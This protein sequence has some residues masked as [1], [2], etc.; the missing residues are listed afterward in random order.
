MH[1]SRFGR[2]ALGLCAL[3]LGLMAF[4]ASAAQAEVGSKW[5]VNGVD[6]NPHV[7]KVEVGVKELENKTGSLLSTLVGLATK[8][9]CTGE[10]MTGAVLLLEGH[11]SGGV[12]DYTGCETFLSGVLT[13][14]C[15]PTGGLIKTKKLLGL[16]LLVLGPEG[17]E[18]LV[19]IKPEEG[20]EF[21]VIESSEKCAVGQ[22][23]VIKGEVDLKDCKKEWGKE[24]ST[25]LLEESPAVSK[26]TA[27]NKPASLDGSKIV[28]LTGAHKGLTFSALGSSI[29]P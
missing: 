25:H 12:I 10:T 21:A 27:N 7:L 20:T 19:D 2:K 16:I 15:T 5:M 4:T 13:A 11:L 18:T 1:Q 26:L 3:V 8:L 22:K 9:L 24:K 28:E 14:A 6:L 29:I 23:I 17:L